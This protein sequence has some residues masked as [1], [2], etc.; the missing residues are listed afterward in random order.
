MMTVRTPI[1]E[2]P[3]KLAFG[4]KAVISAEVH[5]ANHRVMKYQDEENE[6]QLRF[7]LD[8]I[9]EVRMGGT[10]ISKV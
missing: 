2:I 7:N 9:D 8:L 5:M 10:Q 6:E 3:F 1:G 4:S